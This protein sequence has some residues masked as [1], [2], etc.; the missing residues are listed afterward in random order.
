MVTAVPSFLVVHHGQMI[1]HLQAGISRDYL[2][3]ELLKALSISHPQG[4]LS[5][6]P[7]SLASTE[8][9]IHENNH[10]PRTCAPEA[11][12]NQSNADSTPTTLTNHPAANASDR[13]ISAVDASIASNGR[14]PQAIQNLLADRRQ[15]LNMDKQEK[16]AAEKA[17]RKSKENARKESIKSAPESAKSKQPSYAQQQKKR[18]QEAKSDRE[19]I[20]RQIKYDKAE[21]REKERRKAFAK[22][23]PDK[24]DEADNLMNEPLSTEITACRS[25]GQ[26]GCALQVRLLDGSTIRTK[27]PSDQTLRNHVRSWVDRQ[28]SDGDIPYTFKL[29]QSPLPNRPI[30]I[31]EEEESLNSLGLTPSA[32]LVVVPIQGFFPAYHANE[33]VVSRGASAS[34]G[35]FSAGAS[36]IAGAFTAAF[37]VGRAA[38]QEEGQPPTPTVVTHGIESR[39]NKSGSSY[40]TLEDQLD[41]HDNNQLYNGNHVILCCLLLLINTLILILVAQFR[42]PTRAEK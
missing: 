33:G 19:R 31:S 23:Q 28:R 39:S 41:S 34:Y 22:A 2:K 7:N 25:T 42:T 27:F 6:E 13:D 40:Q 15:R 37:G 11:T 20:V 9:S 35:L 8:S 17:E 18:Q 36:I 12:S 29:I 10:N 16:D 1:L 3:I 4:L 24:K 5:N 32:N 14:P 26:E 30:L 38:A 21:R